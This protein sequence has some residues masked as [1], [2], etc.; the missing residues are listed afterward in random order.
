MIEFLIWFV[1][2]LFST[3][4]YAYFYY[5]I[6]DSKKSLNFK[7]ILIFIFGDLFLSIIKYYNLTILSVI[8]YFLYCPFLFYSLN[9][10]KYKK[11]I[12]YFVLIWLSAMLL[13]FLSMVILSVL[14]LFF[15]LDVHHLIFTIL[16]SMLVS[17]ILVIFSNNSF[18]KKFVMKFS[19]YFAKAEM[20]DFMLFLFIF[21]ILVL[22]C[23]LAFNIQNITI[24]WLVIA[25]FIISSLFVIL[26]IKNR[27]DKY[28]NKV[29]L[30]TLK[31]NNNF[32]VSMD[33]ENRIFKHNLMAKML[34]IKS[35]SNKR[36][37]E[38]IDELLKEFNTNVDFS[39]HMY[40]IPYGI[41]GIIY[42]KLYPYVDKLDVK[43]DN[44]INDDIFD[45]LKARRYN[46]FVEKMVISLDNA[47]ESSLNS[48]EKLLVIN[49]FATDTEVIMEIKNSFD[50]SLN[51]DEIGTLNY[52][53]KGSKRG[54]GLFSIFRN[55]EAN[56]KLKIVNN[57]FVVK[58]SAKKKE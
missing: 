53:T 14:N 43:I 17:I 33:V 45:F 57:L 31:E 5:N 50:N 32:Y 13:D 1:A 29:F 26:F 28:E 19:S 51:I 52:S 10:L 48:I 2:S 37:R 30:E 22:A 9:P 44:R 8:S 23:V 36:A 24:I 58:I 54:L 3:F 47:I 46:V 6:S 4:G 15:T 49:L 40:D 38:M 55:K 20:I 16:P 7:T 11:F 41:N 34:V 18:V 35:V 12:F 42:Q 25:L 56:V 39:Q 21:Y 27:L